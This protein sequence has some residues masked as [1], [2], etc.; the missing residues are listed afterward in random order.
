MRLILKILDTLNWPVSVY[1]G[2]VRGERRHITI[3]TSYLEAYTGEMKLKPPE[4]ISE[5]MRV[6]G[7]GGG[8]DI[9]H[10]ET[11]IKCYFEIKTRDSWGF[12]T[13]F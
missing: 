10:L 7:E 6:V 12:R 8:K 4:M 13:R 5:T 3:I 9:L 1:T 2:L 11:I